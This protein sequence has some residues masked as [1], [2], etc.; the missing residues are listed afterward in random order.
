MSGLTARAT[1]DR[2]TVDS[3]ANGAVVASGARA[4]GGLLFDLGAIDLAQRLHDRAHIATLNAHRGDMALLDHIIWIS[5]DF[6]QSVALKVAKPNEF[7][8][9]GH[10]PGKP[11]YPGVLMVE[12]AAQLAAYLY[13]I[14]QEK[15]LLAAFTRIDNCSFRNSVVPGDEL[16]LLCQEVKWSRRGFVCDV[17][18]MT[19]GKLTFEAR[20]SGLA[21]GE[22]TP[23]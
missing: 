13:N 22:Q 20:I 11:M 16:F 18:G 3:G 14:R 19:N 15:K 4:A 10:F 12:S 1:A 2:S 7:W 8:V 21:I 9:P 17:Q 6:R 23:G 5:P